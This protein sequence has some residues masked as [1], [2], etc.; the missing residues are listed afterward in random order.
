[1]PW[2]DN[3]INKNPIWLWMDKFGLR[4]S[5]SA[6]ARFARQNVAARM[7]EMNLEKAQGMDSPSKERGD[8]LAMFLKAQKDRPDFFDDNRVLTMA[9]SMTLAGSETTALSL[10]SVFYNVLKTPHVYE[11]L[12]SELDTATKDG[13]IAPHPEGIVSWSD[14]QKLPYL[15]ACIKEA[16][17]VHPGAGLTLE[18]R[19]PPSGA[20]IAGEF[21]AGG[22]IV[23]CN[24]WVL[25]KRRDVFGDD[26]DVYR[27]ERWILGA[28]ASDADREKVK[29]M[30]ATM[31]QFGAGSRTCI[32]KHISLLEMYK[33][34]PTFLR[35]FEVSLL[36]F[37]LRC[38][39]R[40]NG[41]MLIRRID[42]FRK[43]GSGVEA[44]QR[45]VCTTN[46]FRCYV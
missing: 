18:R 27:P 2:L 15:D 4:D 24:A 23:G 33:L 34:I 44:T 32:G 22:T 46:G 20:E 16:F 45:V 42:Q 36:R 11:K 3:F 30:N 17:R 37:L 12:M 43:T 38:S 14:S 19:V 29:M 9:T 1:M 31:F 13:T 39:S 41:H 10:S 28:D 40:S 8:L 5:T 6:A 35:R 26:V 21:I 7:A 25:H